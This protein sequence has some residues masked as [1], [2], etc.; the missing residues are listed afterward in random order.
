MTRDNMKLTGNAQQTVLNWHGLCRRVPGL[1]LDKR[2]MMNGIM[3]VDEF[4]FGYRSKC[5]KR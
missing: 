4:C 3:Q 1:W 5:G 2:Y